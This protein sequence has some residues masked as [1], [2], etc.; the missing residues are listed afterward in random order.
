MFL[1]PREETAAIGREKPMCEIKPNLPAKESEFRLINDR[2]DFQADVCQHQ[3]EFRG[4]VF[5]VS[6]LDWYTETYRI[7]GH[8][9]FR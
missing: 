1:E 4:L 7:T 3:A 9:V 8:I 6:V 5:G 2:C